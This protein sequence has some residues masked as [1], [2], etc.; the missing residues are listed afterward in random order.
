ME[1]SSLEGIKKLFHLSNIL[2]FF[3]C[4]ATRLT[5]H[6]PLGS[7]SGRRLHSLQTRILGKSKMPRRCCWRVT[8]GPEDRCPSPSPAAFQYNTGDE[9]RL[10]TQIGPREVLAQ[11][12][13]GKWESGMPL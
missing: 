4:S 13:T 5:L 8:Q 6:C 12:L 11:P 9:S 10:W 1:K 7:R 2:T 3:M